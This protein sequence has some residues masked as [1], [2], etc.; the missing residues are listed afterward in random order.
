[1][2]EEN[3]HVISVEKHR[4]HSR[5]LVARIVQRF[6]NHD[7]AYGQKPSQQMRN[8]IVRILSVDIFIFLLDYYL[9]FSPCTNEEHSVPKHSQKTGGRPTP[10]AGVE[11]KPG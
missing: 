6:D 3:M 8:Y 9:G 4:A 2:R 5:L 10:T 7:F 11:K 1:M